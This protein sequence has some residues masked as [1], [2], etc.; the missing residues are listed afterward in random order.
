[1]FV[2]LNHENVLNEIMKK[3]QLKSRR[4]VRYECL[5]FSFNYLFFLICNMKFPD[6]DLNHMFILPEWKKTM[7]RNY[8]KRFKYTI[9]NPMLCSH[10]NK[11][12]NIKN[13]RDGYL[14]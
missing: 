13:I 2:V 14:V 3:R 9:L 10:N 8:E 12:L 11:L 7:E 6:F 4:G 1:M 5:E